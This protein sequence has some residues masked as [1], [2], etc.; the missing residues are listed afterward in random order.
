MVSSLQN[1]H[2]FSPM[3]STRHW[4]WSVRLSPSPCAPCL[5]LALCPWFLAF[6]VW[7]NKRLLYRLMVSKEMVLMTKKIKV[8]MESNLLHA[9]FISV[10]VSLLYGIFLIEHNT[11]WLHYTIERILHFFTHSIQLYKP[12][13][14]KKK[15]SDIINT[16]MTPLIY[17]PLTTQVSEV[18]QSI[19]LASFCPL[20]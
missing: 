3:Q 12:K 7:L 16:S 6:L 14:L 17:S 4:G 10:F 5:C 1:R 11:I 18:Q 2:L 20:K 13:G 19:V 9:F 8:Q 15:S